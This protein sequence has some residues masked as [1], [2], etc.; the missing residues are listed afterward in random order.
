M[1]N[2]NNNTISV[3]REAVRCKII[4]LV[5]YKVLEIILYQR[6]IQFKSNILLRTY[7]LLQ[8]Y[9]QSPISQQWQIRIHWGIITLSHSQIKSIKSIIITFMTELRGCQIISFIRFQYTRTSRQHVTRHTVSIR[10]P[11]QN[12]EHEKNAD[13]HFYQKTCK[14]QT[15][16]C[17]DCV[18]DD[19]QIENIYRGHEYGICKKSNI[20]MASVGNLLPRSKFHGDLNFDHHALHDPPVPWKA[21]TINT[22]KHGKVQDGEISEQLCRVFS[23]ETILP[24]LTSLQQMATGVLMH[25]I[26]QLR[27]PNQSSQLQ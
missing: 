15:S 17:T 16:R 20:E 4:I 27:S 11:Q 19:N 22:L 5:L 2:E 24:Y 13:K 21:C 12:T 8:F 6:N 7:M 3:Q 18:H 25:I 9:M 23:I 10:Q 14:L 1:W 26:F